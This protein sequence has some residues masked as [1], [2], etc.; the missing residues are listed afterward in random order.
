MKKIYGRHLEI[1]D[2]YGETWD[3]LSFFKN[4]YC[5][6][7]EVKELQEVFIKDSYEEVVNFVKKLDLRYNERKALFTNTRVLEVMGLMHMHRLTS[8]QSADSM[9]FRI[10][11]S[12]ESD[13]SMKELMKHLSNKDFRA[14]AEDNNLKYFEKRG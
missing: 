11:Y 9:Q 4:D 14:W 5:Y 8:K 2:D 3:F 12:D 1:S 6:I 7:E 13:A 10:K